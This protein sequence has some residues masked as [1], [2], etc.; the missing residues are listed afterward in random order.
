MLTQASPGPNKPAGV[1]DD[2]SRS[3]QQPEVTLHTSTKPWLRSTKGEGIGVPELDE[4][5]IVPVGSRSTITAPAVQSGASSTLSS[6]ILYVTLIVP[7]LILLSRLAS[8]S[9]FDQACICSGRTSFSG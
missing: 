7:Q 5:G 2:L 4:G 3:E 8:L 1:T 6:L 9:T